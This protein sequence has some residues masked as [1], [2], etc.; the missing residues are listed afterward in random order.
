[1]FKKQLL[2]F[3]PAFRKGV[4]FLGRT[5]KSLGSVANLI[6][7]ASDITN[8]DTYKGAEKLTLQ[9][10]ARNVLEKAKEV[11]AEGKNVGQPFGAKV[12]QRSYFAGVDIPPSAKPDANA[13][14]LGPA[15]VE[16]P[17]VVSFA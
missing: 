7:T 9:D 10:A 1:M 2:G 15:P 17:A 12:P 14:T 5:S 13:P 3:K 11:E 16:G 6:K 8:P 4:S